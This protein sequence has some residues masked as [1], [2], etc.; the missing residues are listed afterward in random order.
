MAGDELIS[1]TLPL[2]FRVLDSGLE[3][4]TTAADCTGALPNYCLLCKDGGYECVRW[5]CDPPGL[6]VMAPVCGQR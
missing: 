2:L 3:S 6:C 1:I 5:S 4:C